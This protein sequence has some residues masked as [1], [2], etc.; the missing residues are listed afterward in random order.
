MERKYLDGESWILGN[1]LRKTVYK[2]QKVII[3]STVYAGY[4]SIH[5]YSYMNTNI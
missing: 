4:G 2:F 3:F 5:L 1:Y